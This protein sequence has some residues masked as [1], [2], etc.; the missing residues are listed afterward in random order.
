MKLANKV[1]LA[2]PGT[3][4]SF[5]LAQQLYKHNLLCAFYTG[6]AFGDGSWQKEIIDWLPLNYQNKISNRFLTGVPHQLIKNNFIHELKAIWKLKNKKNAE[7]VLFER[8]KLFQEGIPNS[9]I[10]ASDVIVGFD[11]SSWILAKRCK[12]LGKKFILD[13]S[14]AHPYEKQKVYNIISGQYPEWAFSLKQKSQ[15]FI[16]LELSEMEMA[17]EIIVASLFTKNTL[18]NYGIKENKIHVIPYGTDIEI[19]KP[20]IHKN[21]NKTRFVFVGLVDARKGIPVLLEAWDLM[22]KKNA[23]L[24]LI[25]PL[26]NNIQLLIKS[27]FPEVILTGKIPYKDLAA[28]L[29]K[30]DVL[31][32]PSYFEGFGLV[33]PEAMACGL[34][35]ITTAATCGP[36]ILTNSLDGYLI[37]S[38]DAKSLLSHMKI[39]LENRVLLKNLQVAALE[40][41]QKLTWNTYGEKWKT[42]IE[43]L[44]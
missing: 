41:A 19:F 9:A 3:Q 20:N 21:N 40:K 31:V 22:N 37:P 43:N 7:R 12:D 17:D 10:K 5:H 30:Y 26:S 29:P 23:E 8:N 24:T 38:G 28:E 13:I 4:H 15:Y 32:F 2:H 33:I 35:V 27:Q 25:G 16:D 39:L 1:L 42:L 18:I 44:Q 11:T 14:I 6:I 36:D 34:T